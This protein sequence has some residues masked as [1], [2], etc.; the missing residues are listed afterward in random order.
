[1]ERLRRLFS[2]R[3][4]VIGVPYA[5]LLLFFLL[6]FFIVFKISVSEMEAVTFKDLLTLKEGVLQLTAEAGQL[7]LHHPGRAVFQDL[8]GQRE[9]RR[10]H[11]GAVPGHRLP[12]CLLHGPCAAHRAAGAA[13]AGDAALLDQLPAAGVRVARPAGRER[14]G[15]R[16]WSAW[17]STSCWPRRA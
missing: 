5:F 10:R 9:V 7:R 3:G 14:L 8:P 16:R 11:H 13:D 2:G 15:G 17:A 1:M 4:A 6:P 12:L